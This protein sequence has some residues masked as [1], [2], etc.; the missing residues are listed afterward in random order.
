[1]A[2]LNRSCSVTFAAEPLGQHRGELGGLA[3]DRRGRSRTARIRASGRARRRRPGTCPVGPRRRQATRRTRA[4][5]RSA[6]QLASRE[7]VSAWCSSS[8][9]DETRMRPEL[10]DRR[11]IV[12][13]MAKRRMS[14]RRDDGLVRFV[15]RSISGCVIFGAYIWINGRTDDVSNPT[16]QFEEPP[17]PKGSR[18]RSARRPSSGRSTASRPRARAT[19]PRP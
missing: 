17:Q 2:V 7:V 19:S 3:L 14:K 13:A 9:A 16:W 12:R 1:M 10:P 15:P 6:L 5:L 18:C 8:R 4:D 11:F